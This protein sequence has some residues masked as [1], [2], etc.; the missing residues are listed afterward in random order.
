RDP[1]LL[2]ALERS[3]GFMLRRQ[4]EDGTISLGGT[5][6]HSPPDTGFVINGMTQIYKLLH[7]GDW[8]PVRAVEEKVK[9]FLERAIPAMLS[10]GCHTPN[11]RWVIAAALGSLHELFGDERLISRAE[12]WLAEGMDCTN[13]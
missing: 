10:G 3:A 6:F 2:A 11:H 7:R 12:E 8:E 4:H 13:D 9:L 1:Q 5:N